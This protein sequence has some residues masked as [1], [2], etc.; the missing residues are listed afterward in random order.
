MTTRRRTGAGR[1]PGKTTGLRS[2][3]FVPLRGDF[4]TALDSGLRRNDGMGIEPWNR[5]A[6]TPTLALPLQ[7]GGDLLGLRRNHG[8]EGNFGLRRNDEEGAR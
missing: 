2:S 5:S 6:S 4:L 1:C 7:G 3:G 8:M